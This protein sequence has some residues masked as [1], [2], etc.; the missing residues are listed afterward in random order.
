MALLK[1][2]HKTRK[3]KYYVMDKGY[4]SEYIYIFANKRATRCDSYDSFETKKKNQR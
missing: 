2:C 1:L 4:D 3:S